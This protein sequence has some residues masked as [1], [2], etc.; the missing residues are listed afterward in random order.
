M[1]QGSHAF[2]LDVRPL[3]MQP[4]EGGYLA[5]FPYRSPGQQTAKV[6][7]GTLEHAAMA[8]CD[9]NWGR[10]YRE[11]YELLRRDPGAFAGAFYEFAQRFAAMPD[12][13]FEPETMVEASPY[14]GGPLRYTRPFGDAARPFALLVPYTEELAR[15]Y[16]ELMR[17]ED[18]E[19][20]SDADA[21]GTCA[22]AP[23]LRRV[24]AVWRAPGLA[25]DR[26]IAAAPDEVAEMG[27]GRRRDRPDASAAPPIPLEPVDLLAGLAAGLELHASDAS[28]DGAST[29]VA[30]VG[31]MIR[32]GEATVRRLIRT[33]S[34]RPAAPGTPPSDA[35]PDRAGVL[36]PTRDKPGE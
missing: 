23:P 24:A 4:V 13:E 29:D 34:L 12:V 17:R 11:P 36:P 8:R 22:E 7:I 16:A 5:H 18:A 1:S 25:P 30:E 20:P 2:E 15:G 31:K 3:D 35:V 21:R 10:H 9:P 26:V 32:A 33:A 28:A 27:R 14:R 6:V 19:A